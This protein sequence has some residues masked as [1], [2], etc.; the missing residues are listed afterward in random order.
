MFKLG[1]NP[2]QEKDKEN[3]TQTHLKIFQRKERH[4][5]FKRIPV[6]QTADFATETMG[7]GI[8]RLEDGE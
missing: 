4:V 5:T 2:K 8:W 7:G 6:T 3:H 1:Y